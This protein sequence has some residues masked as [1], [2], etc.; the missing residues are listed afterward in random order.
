MDDLRTAAAALQ[1]NSR[2]V[3]VKRTPQ[4]ADAD[5][6][7]NVW[8]ALREGYSDEEIYSADEIGLFYKLMLDQSFQFEGQQ[9]RGNYYSNCRVR[10]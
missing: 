4:E 8:P 10:Y 3:R 2:V 6:L 9:C 7:R 5:W 1:Y